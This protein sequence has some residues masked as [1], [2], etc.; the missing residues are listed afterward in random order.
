[1]EGLGRPLAR[2]CFKIRKNSQMKIWNKCTNSSMILAK[3]NLKEMTRWCH[4][5]VAWNGQKIVNQLSKFKTKSKK[6]MMRKMR[7]LLI[8]TDNWILYLKVKN[9]RRKVVA[10][11]AMILSFSR[12][13]LLKKLKNKNWSIYQLS[14]KVK[15]KGKTQCSVL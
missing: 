14:I 1:M 9:K 6:M 11:K 15:V 2:K 8:V 3:R 12:T 4:P 7:R 5:T 10:C 13:K